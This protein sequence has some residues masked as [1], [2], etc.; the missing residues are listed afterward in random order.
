M[1]KERVLVMNGSRLL[2]QEVG[3]KWAVKDVKPAEGLK[4]GI[5]NI[6]NAKA[7]NKSE[8]TTGTILHVDQDVIYQM[9]GKDKFIKHNKA[10][11]VSAPSVGV[12]VEIDY[13][14]G[15]GKSKVVDAQARSRSR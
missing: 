14:A 8:S 3:S 6:Y 7:A 11:M 13:S 9:V 15:K 2:E 4:P 12:H 5:Y 1:A 10:D